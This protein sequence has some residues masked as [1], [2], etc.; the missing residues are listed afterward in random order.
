MA[1]AFK[2]IFTSLFVLCF[3]IALLAFIGAFISFVR[4]PF[5]SQSTSPS[6]LIRL[7]PFNIIFSPARLT[8]AG[9]DSRNRLGKCL[10]IFIIAI[11]LGV[12]SGWLVMIM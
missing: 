3:V 2:W 8:E 9:K 1:L 10:S 6:P 4:I 11:L 12:V 5:N 7:N